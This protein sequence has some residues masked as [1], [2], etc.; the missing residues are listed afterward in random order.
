VT[1]DITGQKTLT[2][3]G[4]A[5]AAWNINGA[6]NWVDEAQAPEKFFTADSVVFPEGG[7]N[8]SVA[9]TGLIA[10]ASIAVSSATTNYTFTSTAG[11]QITGSTGIT[12][13]GASTLTL[14]G[15]NSYTGQT[16]IAGGTVAISS[17]ASLGEGA[18]PSNSLALSGGGRLSYTAATAAD[19]G[20]NRSIAVGTGGGS[21]S[22]NNATAATIT[23]PG[24]ITGSGTDNLSFHS[25]AA[26]TGTF[27]LTGDNSGFTGR[28]SVDPPA[29]A[30][31]LTVLRIGGQSAVPAGGSITL[32]YPANATTS[33]NSVALDLPGISLPAAVTLNLTSGATA[34][35]S[36]RSQ[37]TS[38]G[39]S[40]INGP[41]TLS[42]VNATGTTQLPVVQFQVNSGTLTVNGN[43]TESSPGAFTGTNQ[44]NQIATLF[45]RG[46]GNTVIN[47]TINLPSAAFVR[48]DNDGSLTINSTGNVWALTE[49][50]SSSTLRLGAHNA[51]A[52]MSLLNV[53]Q[54]SDAGNS[55]FDL[56]GFNQELNG[57]TSIAGNAANTRR[58]TNTSATLS[59]L[60][61]NSAV[62]RVFGNAAGTAGNIS[63][64]IALV[65]NGTNTQTI[66]GPANSFTGPTTI[67]EGTLRIIGTITASEVTVAD[68][69]TL[70]GTGTI[71]TAVIVENNGTVSPGVNVG[72][73]NLGGLSLA[74]DAVLRFELDTPEVVGGTA[75]DLLAVSGPF[76]LD[77]TLQV[78]QLAGFANGN[79]RLAN[80][81]GTFVNNVLNL[82]PSFLTAFPGSM[83]DVSTPGQVNLVVVPEP[84]VT[85]GVLSAVGMLLGLS[86]SRR[87]LA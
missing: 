76:T 59:T 21:I 60:T 32:N 41:I 51:I 47:G 69:G 87:R 46:V 78:V 22:H 62:D 7:L 63:G 11:N 77:G 36:L 8:P 1:F 65:K 70:A 2:W 34:A 38:N 14:A 75:N 81:A 12:K 64:N 9:L 40:T 4:A 53:G 86:R 45:A 19:L 50:R 58:V 68:G 72:T 83:I 33:G 82:E 26:G 52:T 13:T 85:L 39:T 44:T 37:V 27:V 74:S 23:I 16:N 54:A 25:N 84:S 30:G 10:P 17:V 3:T 56:N 55:V 15:P 61:L 42:A 29:V 5:S 80:Y 43:I 6:V 66:A 18:F 73:L 35:L 20:V 79:Y 48:V 24:N 67:N 28:I 49:V 71:S 31:G 57:L